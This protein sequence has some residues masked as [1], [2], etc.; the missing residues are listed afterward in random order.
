MI[1]VMIIIY[2]YDGIG[3]NCGGVPRCWGAGGGGMR[4]ADFRRCTD[5]LFEDAPTNY[6]PAFNK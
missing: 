1:M 3:D 5:E 2:D 4:T 6:R